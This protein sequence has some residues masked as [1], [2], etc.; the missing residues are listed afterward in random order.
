ME[1]DRGRQKEIT[2]VITVR[3][4]KIEEKHVRPV[5]RDTFKTVGEV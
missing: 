5:D 4:S 1:E 2:E 3:R